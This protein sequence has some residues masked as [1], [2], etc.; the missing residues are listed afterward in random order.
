MNEPL[1]TTEILRLAASLEAPH[2]L[3]RD[4][5]QAELRSPT[6]GSRITTTI[7]VDGN[8][9][10]A[11]IS[12]KVHACAFGQASAALLERSAPGRYREEV[13]TALAELTDWLAGSDIE[14]RWPGLKALAPARSRKSRHGAILLP[15]RALEA[16]LEAA[17]NA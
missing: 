2:K 4:D 3:D 9:K 10:V 1:Y 17:A 12:Q 15:F 13:T 14:P 7:T 5:G 8:G 11:A 6:C 16:A